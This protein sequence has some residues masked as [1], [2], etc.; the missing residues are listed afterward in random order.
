[1][2]L[3]TLAPPVPSPP[4]PGEAP[5]AS[6]PWFGTPTEPT[7]PASPT[8]PNTLINRQLLL[9][10]G[11]P[12]TPEG[13]P[14]IP[15]APEQS[16]KE[17][18]PAL[19]V[20]Y[21]DDPIGDT[22]SLFDMQHHEGQAIA[23]RGDSRTDQFKRFNH[24]AL[25]HLADG[26][27][28]LRKNDSIYSID[29]GNPSATKKLLELDLEK[30][31]PGFVMGQGW[32]V[33][34]GL[35]DAP[36]IGLQIRNKQEPERASAKIKRDFV[37]SWAVDPTGEATA[38]GIVP[39]PRKTDRRFDRTHAVADVAVH[40]TSLFRQADEAMETYRKQ[41]PERAKSGL[42]FRRKRHAQNKTN[43]ST[44]EI[45][46]PSSLGVSIEG[47]WSYGTNRELTKPA[48]LADDKK[49]VFSL[50]T[51]SEESDKIDTYDA[52]NYVNGI[53][54]RLLTSHENPPASLEEAKQQMT[55]AVQEVAPLIK[56]D[57]LVGSFLNIVTIDDV[58]YGVWGRTQHSDEGG[59]V[60]QNEDGEFE[61]I[62]AAHPGESVGAVV[63]DKGDRIAMVTG[64]MIHE[65][66]MSDEEILEAFN[67]NPQ[68]SAANFL[69]RKLNHANDPNKGA[70]VLHVTERHEQ[71]SN[72]QKRRSKLVRGAAA[73][74]IKR[75]RKAE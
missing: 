31:T 54:H 1:M 36:V 19:I 23:Y 69:K 39:I 34:K 50:V 43:T 46:E 3:E 37:R 48:V 28:L 24:E 22:V 20:S 11:S 74:L 35:N 73:M 30:E 32:D 5:D 70:L 64:S 33:L 17:P 4:N 67:G 72:K 75:S 16:L 18:T 14:M 6:A 71:T 44:Q 45:Q 65:D 9:N 13:S 49:G 41:P 47:A 66:S 62:T 21:D 68:V 40:G 38:A 25:I 60:L 61:E 10:P 55:D 56:K 15:Q 53:A 8:V 7:P 27:I 29:L 57:A 59:I 58:T 63:L 42:G 52:S 12:G 2:S 51:K 26:S